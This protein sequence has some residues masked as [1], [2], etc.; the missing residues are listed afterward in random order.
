[1][2]IQ[3]QCMDVSNT[4]EYFEGVEHITVNLTSMYQPDTCTLEYAYIQ[5]NISVNDNGATAVQCRIF[6]VLQER[7]QHGANV[8][9]SC[10]CDQSNNHHKM[11]LL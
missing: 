3:L 9:D 10:Y 1:M 4:K 11:A 6:S 7:I 8:C 2:N 5:A